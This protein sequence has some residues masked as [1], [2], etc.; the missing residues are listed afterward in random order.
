MANKENKGFLYPQEKKTNENQPDF[1]GTVNVNGQDF[2]LA[3]W[4]NTSKKD[5]QYLSLAVSDIQEE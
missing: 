2:R 5:V 1:T 4:A 3:A